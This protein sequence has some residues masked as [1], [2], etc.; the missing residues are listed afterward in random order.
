MIDLIYAGVWLAGIVA[1]WDMVRRVTGTRDVRALNVRIGEVDARVDTLRLNAS[2]E[3]QSRVALSDEHGKRLHALEQKLP[4]IEKQI[5]AVRG[6]VQ[7]QPRRVGLG[8][9]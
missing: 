5:A 6:M 4:E 2:S 8:I 3:H 7:P 1:A 9:R